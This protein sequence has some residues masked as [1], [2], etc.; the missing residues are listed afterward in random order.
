MKNN[1]SSNFEILGSIAELMLEKLEF[2]FACARK[3]ET[4]YVHEVNIFTGH[5]RFWCR[6]K[7]TPIFLQ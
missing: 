2:N 5:E 4:I 6:P 7:E 1:L 3:V